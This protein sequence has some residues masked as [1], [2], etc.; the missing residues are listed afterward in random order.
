M[1]NLTNAA[2]SGLK[3]EEAALEKEHKRWSERR[4]LALRR[5]R[6]HTE[7]QAGVWLGKPADIIAMRKRLEQASQDE[8]V[9]MEIVN[10]VREKRDQL[11][12]QAVRHYDNRYK[13]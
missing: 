8:K 10:E 5:I 4:E 11:L 6:A 13:G 9:L 3:Q 1:E 7:P 12:Q 2:L